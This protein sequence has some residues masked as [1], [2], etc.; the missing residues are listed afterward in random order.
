LAGFLHP[1]SVQ[2]DI[3]V[4]NLKSAFCKQVNAN[5]DVTHA[6]KRLNATPVPVRIKATR[7]SLSARAA[8]TSLS[9]F[10]YMTGI[11]SISADCNMP[12]IA[13]KSANPDNPAANEKLDQVEMNIHVRTYMGPRPTL[14]EMLLHLQSKP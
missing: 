12:E 14:P 11:V 8:R 4:I 13:T 2:A 5:I 1:G 3:V 7:T 9:Y 10:S 6:I